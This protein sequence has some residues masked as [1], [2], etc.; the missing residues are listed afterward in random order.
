MRDEKRLRLASRPR[1]RRASAFALTRRLVRNHMRRHFWQI[2]A[3][4]ACMALAA[5]AMAA[6][7]Y[8][9]RPI[10][11]D[12]FVDRSAKALPW[13]G[14]IV[15]ALF[16]LRGLATFGQ[17]VLMTQ[18]SNRI[19]AGLQTDLFA[20]LIR[21]DLAFFHD[22]SAGALL[23]R[24][25]SDVQLLR[26]S[27]TA[28]ITSFGRDFLTLIAMIVV[29]FHQ[30]WLLACIAFFAFPTAVLPILQVGQR[31][32][33]ISRQTQAQFSRLTGQLNESL[34]GARHVKAYNMEEHEIRRASRQIHEV[35]HKAMR[36]AQWRALLAPIL[37]TLSGM[38]VVAIIFY[39]G[40]QVIGG[41]KTQGQ[42]FSF[43]AALLSAYEPL[44]RLATWNTQY[45]EGLAAAERIFDLLDIKPKIVDAPDAKPLAL[46]RG[47]VRFENVDFAYLPGRSALNGFT[48]EIPGGSTIALVGPSGAGKSTALNLI[49][50]FYDVTAGR[51]AIDGQDVRGVTLVSLR[52]AIGLVSQEIVLFDDTIRTNIIYGR[53]QASEVEM[54][55]AARS[56]GAHEFIA[57]LPEGY[58]SMIGAHG[59]KLSGGQRQRIVIARAMLKNAP[60]LLLDEA[61][62]SLDTESERHVQAALARL[63]EGRTTIMIAHRLSTVVDADRICVLSEGRVVEQGTHGELMALGGLYARLHAL[64]FAGQDASAAEPGEA[65]EGD[66]PYPAQEARALA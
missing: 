37:E 61:T 18:I 48:L 64:Q 39:G 40:Y 56:A 12:V 50:R 3:A 51:V 9:V 20:H 1:K 54:I 22:N 47:A 6:M 36:A 42:L 11:D 17:Q 43:M 32:R 44:K 8:M 21:A 53:P 24:F 15:M 38:A 4:V 60:I 65:G 41:L 62:S 7:I 59:V 63:K 16:M 28:T 25:V 2:T 10:L 66:G 23:S 5:G 13:I 49:P 34:Q 58:D 45:Q 46:G 19:I 35:R 31:I 57:S 55:E 29:M 27:I 26:M 52:N 30:D 33:R 14:G